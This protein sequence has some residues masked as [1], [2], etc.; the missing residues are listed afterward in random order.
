[1]SIFKRAKDIMAANMNALFDSWED[2]AKMVDQHLRNLAKDLAEVKQ[3]T[4][5][6]MAEE[7]RAN[8]M[9]KEKQDG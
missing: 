6:V 8:R 9:L 2:P 3:A 7:T 4:A 1:M 5:G